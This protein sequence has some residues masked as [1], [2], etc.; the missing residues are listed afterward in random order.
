MKNIIDLA[1]VYNTGTV[2]RQY[3]IPWI[4]K[5]L[6]ITDNYII[7]NDNLYNRDLPELEN[8][9]TVILDLSHNPVD[10]L[11]HQH[12]V[13]SF[14]QL[15]SNKNVIVLSDD[16]NEKYYTSYFHLPY[17]EMK[18]PFEEKNL[19]HQFSCLNSVPKIHRLIMLNKIYQH[20]LQ[21]HVL[22]SFLWDKQQHAKNHLQT[23]YW[24]QDVS[25]YKNEYQY[26]LD[27]I[28]SMCPITIDTIS[29]TDSY[30]NDHT[31]SSPAY[32]QTALNI[33]TES[34]HK[35]LFF[36]EKTWKAIY[37]KQL[38]MSIN[39]PR[40]IEKL[41]QFGFDVFRDLID[42]SYDKEPNLVK[43]VEMCVSEI[44]RLKDDIVD[45]FHYTEQRRA[46]N[47]LHLQSRDFRQLVEISV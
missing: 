36:T 21:D 11:G 28:K 23:D 39:A 19:V 29:E 26:F 17:S 44:N 25:E 4:E 3:L 9:E 10:C 2:S 37:S 13:Q 5:K 30:L 24:Q 46:N 32:N 8:F 40:S 22:H 33:I 47:F 27:N 16:A 14:I 45:I 34:S 6:G 12:C 7:V 20:N 1:D 43:R 31:V 42:H 35:R 18:Y 15:H 38:F 41:E